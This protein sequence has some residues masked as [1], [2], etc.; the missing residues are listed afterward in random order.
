MHLVH[1]HVWSTS[2]YTHTPFLDA[3]FLMGSLPTNAPF[4]NVKTAITWHWLLNH[5]MKEKCTLAS[6]QFWARHPGQHLSV[7]LLWDCQALT[8]LNSALKSFKA[9]VQHFMSHAVKPCKRG[10]PNVTRVHFTWSIF[11]ALNDDVSKI[12]ISSQQ[13]SMQNLKV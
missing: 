1:S 12:A 5:C 9:E 13:K 8:M 3:L 7:W 11:V 6:K 4:M 10:P 2:S